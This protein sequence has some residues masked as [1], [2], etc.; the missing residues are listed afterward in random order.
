M[1]N[2]VT[3]NL[4]EYDFSILDIISPILD[5]LEFNK[6]GKK[7]ITE[8]QI[9]K[10][11]IPKFTSIIKDNYLT[12]RLVG[13]V[14]QLPVISVYN[15]GYVSRVKKEVITCISFLK[16]NDNVQFNLMNY[17]DN[18][19]FIKPRLN[20]LYVFPSYSHYKVIGKD[21]MLIRWGF[22]TNTRVIHKII[23]GRW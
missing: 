21:Y 16:T 10:L 18:P 20:K 7:L 4:H 1:V 13:G 14:P 19:L 9:N 2:V 23:G 15:E 17:V 12:G 11:L 8:N 3:E 5:N 6:N 22:D